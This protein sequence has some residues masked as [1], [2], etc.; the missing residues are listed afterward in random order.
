MRDNDLSLR[1][2]RKNLRFAAIDID[3]LL[4]DDP[5]LAREISQ[6]CLD[7]IAK[8]SLSPLPVT[9]FPYADYAKA[10]R[11]MAAG[12]HQGKLV[13]IAPPILTIPDSRSPTCGRCSILT[14]L[15]WSL[16]LWADS[17]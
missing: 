11:Q 3:R 15:I 14:R 4:L 7:L 6:A 8:G 17:A 10:I 1:V 2:F 9:A 16:A 12:Q 5:L 13:L